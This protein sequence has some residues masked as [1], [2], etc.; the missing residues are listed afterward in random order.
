[1]TK[2]IGSYFLV[3]VG[4]ALTMVGIQILLG[5]CPIKNKTQKS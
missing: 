2:K 3:A 5:K 4:A 1:M